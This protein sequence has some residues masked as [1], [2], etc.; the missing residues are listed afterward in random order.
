MTNV[1]PS[2]VA[3][4]QA[5]NGTEGAYWAAHADRFDRA[6]ERYHPRFMAAAEVRPGSTVLDI[7]C[8]TGQTTRAAAGLAAG[9]GGG[10]ALGIDLSADMIAVARAR[11]GAEA[12][13]NASFVCGDAQVHPFAEGSFD[14]AISRTGAMFFGDPG[15]A[16]ANIA[17]ALRPG[18]PLTLLTWQPPAR[19]EWIGAFVGALAGGPPPAPPAPGAPG[20]FSLSDP[21]LVRA[22]L[23]RAGFHRVEVTGVSEPE[24]FGRDV[25]EA[26]TFVLGLLG[27]MLDGRDEAGRRAASDRLRATL[28]DHLTADGVAY[29]SAAWLVTARRAPLSASG[30]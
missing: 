22:V 27:W 28:A 18:S 26:H 9:P 21:S 17:R 11:A 5:W 4:A 10:S 12:V 3:Q 16:F 24:F 15:R 13:P 30:A 7:G 14:C 8:G 25:D 29:G 1:D 20:P 23:T 19:N 2:N 6:V